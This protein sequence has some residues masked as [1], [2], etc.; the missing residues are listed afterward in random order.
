MPSIP[1]RVSEVFLGLR[2]DEVW[3]RISSRTELDDHRRGKEGIAKG[4]ALSITNTG[5]VAYYP[6]MNFPRILIRADAP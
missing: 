3:I 6:V 2:F 1:R 4:E 5:A